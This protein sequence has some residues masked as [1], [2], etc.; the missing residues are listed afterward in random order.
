MVWDD[1]VDVVCYGSGFG[2]LA[3]AIVAVDA[4]LEVFVARSGSEP[5]AAPGSGA[6]WLGSGV[7]DQ[8][9]LDYF[10]ALSG[11]VELVAGGSSDAD[12]AV[13]VVSD[14]VPAGPRARIEPFYG[15]RLRDWAAQCLVSPYGV[16]YT[17]ILD[18]DT[19]PMKTRS[20]EEIQVKV[21]G[22]VEPGTNAASAVN[23]W[24]LTQTRERDIEISDGCALQRIVFE[25]G[26]VLGAVIDTA[27]G[28]LALRAR[29]G[30]AITT[31]S[32][33]IGTTDMTLP[34]SDPGQPLQVCLV[35]H[36]A[37]RFARVE[38]LTTE[39]AA[40][41][42]RSAYCRSN[43]VHDGLREAGRSHAR[44]CRKMHRYPPLG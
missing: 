13:R 28:P 32:H 8:E 43:R 27:D 19:T 7:E 3:S 21:V 36:S 1:E 34:V 10:A 37:S 24:L 41:A 25:E 39:T 4:G 44:R 38:L 6:P 9:T 2:G 35:G 20:G 16:L 40:V 11:D 18:R 30:V 17:R 23:E 29:H 14:P 12:L 31:D 26:E 42:P 15:A 5:G 22:A 33:Q